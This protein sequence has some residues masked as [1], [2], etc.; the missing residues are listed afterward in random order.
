[1]DEDD[2]L[3]D[4]LDDVKTPF[5]VLGIHDAPNPKQKHT[6]YKPT[7]N[8]ATSDPITSSTPSAAPISRAHGAADTLSSH[9]RPRPFTLAISALS[10]FRDEETRHRH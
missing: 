6:K 1:M 5:D 7:T 9:D 2:D 10:D 8:G 3:L 4:D